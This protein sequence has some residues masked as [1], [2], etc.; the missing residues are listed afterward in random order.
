M[1]WGSQREKDGWR[2]V[3][4]EI[5]SKE[6]GGKGEKDRRERKEKRIEERR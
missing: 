1:R 6:G 4:G 2:K 3:G 5:E